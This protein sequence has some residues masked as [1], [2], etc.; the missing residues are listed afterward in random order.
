MYN[1]LHMARVRKAGLTHGSPTEK[2][3]TLMTGCF[4]IPALQFHKPA[5]EYDL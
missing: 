2:G 5:L 4:S 3:M 1:M